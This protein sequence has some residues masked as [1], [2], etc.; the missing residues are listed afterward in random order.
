MQ[1]FA[2]HQDQTICARFIDNKRLCKGIVEAAQIMSSV[3]F[4]YGEK[5]H[6]YKPTHLHHPC[7]IWARAAP[8]FRWLFI[9][10]KRLLREYDYRFEKIHK[11]EGLIYTFEKFLEEFTAVEFVN[12]TPYKNVKT[13]LAYRMHLANKWKHDKY[14]PRFGKN[15][16]KKNLKGFLKNNWN[17]LKNPPIYDRG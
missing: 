16:L 15:V 8:H 17:Y 3:M 11:C 4:L 7:V 10:F 1:I 2:I 14:R 13:T 12:V 5:N 6:P 9:Y